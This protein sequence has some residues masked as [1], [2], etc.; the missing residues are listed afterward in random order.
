MCDALIPKGRKAA[1]AEAKVLLAQAVKLA[2]ADYGI[3]ARTRILGLYTLAS[4][5]WY[6]QRRSECEAE[7]WAQVG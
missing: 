3:W 7:L 5:S 4:C 1:K 2:K 6:G